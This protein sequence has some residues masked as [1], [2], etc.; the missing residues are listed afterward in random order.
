[1]FKNILLFSFSNN[2]LEVF[3]DETHSYFDLVFDNLPYLNLPE[4]RSNI[5]SA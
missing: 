4:Q 3:K 5:D 1:M 2:L